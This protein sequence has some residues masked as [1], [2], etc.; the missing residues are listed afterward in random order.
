[1]SKD[2]QPAIRG[3]E[4]RLLNGETSCDTAEVKIIRKDRTVA[5]I[6]LAI[7]AVLINGELLSLQYVGSN[8]TEE[9]RMRENQSYYLRQVTRAQVTLYLK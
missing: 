2:S 5:L 3:I 1:M 4:K 9:K 8:I 7:G 6:Q